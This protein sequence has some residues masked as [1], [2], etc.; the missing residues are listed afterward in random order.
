MLICDVP[1]CTYFLQCGDMLKCGVPLC[2][3]VLRYGDLLQ[4]DLVTLAPGSNITEMCC[5][6][7]FLFREVLR[8]RGMLLCAH[9]LFTL[10]PLRSYILNVTFPCVQ[11]FYVAEIC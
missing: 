4:H 5:D 9:N 6:F 11:K 1:L 8:C 7:P 10:A 2:T 3:V